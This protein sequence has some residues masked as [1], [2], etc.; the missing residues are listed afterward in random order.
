ARKSRELVE[1]IGGWMRDPFKR[2]RLELLRSRAERDAQDR[3]PLPFAAVEDLLRA[4]GVDTAGSEIYRSPVLLDGEAFWLHRLRWGQGIAEDKLVRL[5]GA[6]R[7]VL[8][9]ALHPRLQQL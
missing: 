3:I 1:L 4:A 6:L 2:E 9:A 8:P 5:A 7:R